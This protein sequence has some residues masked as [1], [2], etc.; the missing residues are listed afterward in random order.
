MHTSFISCRLYGH[1]AQKAAVA[2]AC[3]SLPSQCTGHKKGPA[4]VTQQTPLKISTTVPHES[5]SG[6]TISE[7]VI[8]HN[9][10]H[11]SPQT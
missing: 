8:P 5:R 1:E 2:S 9:D 11:T 3:R 10:P 4:H 7:P 6:L